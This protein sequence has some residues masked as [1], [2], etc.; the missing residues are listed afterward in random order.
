MKTGPPAFT[1]TGM[2]EPPPESCRTFAASFSSSLGNILSY[3]GNSSISL[4]VGGEDGAGILAGED[5]V[6]VR[7]AGSPA[8]P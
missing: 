2:S 6:D 3:L 1:T 8:A 5:Q 4:L 7:P